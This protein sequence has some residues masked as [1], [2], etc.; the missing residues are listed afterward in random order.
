MQAAILVIVNDYFR[1]S[2]FMAKGGVA[3]L[4][5]GKNP[6]PLLTNTWRKKSTHPPNDTM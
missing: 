2:L 5:G 6:H 4:I 3:K 1:E